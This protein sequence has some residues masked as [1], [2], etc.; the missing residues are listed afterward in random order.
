MKKKNIFIFLNNKL[1]TL[2]TILPFLV[3]LRI[4]NK[5]T[6]IFFYVFNKS[7]YDEIVKNIFLYKIIKSLGELKIFG[8]S[9]NA[10]FKV[11]RKLKIFFHIFRLVII[12]IIDKSIYI[13]FK[14][15]EYFPFNILFLFNAKKCF[16]MEPN[17]WGHSVNLEKSYNIEYERPLNFKKEI[18]FNNYSYLISFSSNSPIVESAKKNNKSIFFLNPTRSD[19]LWLKTCKKE[20]TS[21]LSSNLIFKKLENKKNLILYLVG[22]FDRV[23]GLSK[24]SN[25]EI[26]FRDTIKQIKKLKEVHIIFK[27]HPAANLNLI[28]KSLNNLNFN[29]YDFSYMHTSVLSYFCKFT[30]SNYFS[31]ALA[32]AWFAGSNTIEYTDYDN[33]MLK[34]TKDKSIYPEFVDYFI[35]KKNDIKLINILSNNSLKRNIRNFRY[36]FKEDSKNQLISKINDLLN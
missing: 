23:S 11:I 29:S 28:K 34:L 8:N 26:L 3:L 7:T 1:I 17:T 22:T 32:D 21:L 14:A 12:S 30:I 16:Y 24:N 10:N 20:A 13:H 35:D 31:F 27:P 33:K 5:N 6:N 9:F 25:G 19:P 4:N 15:L 18:T 36:S 2:D